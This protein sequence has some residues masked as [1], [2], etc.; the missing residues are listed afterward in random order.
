[1]DASPLLG[2]SQA[3][4]C[5]TVPRSPEMTIVPGTR[6]LRLTFQPPTSKAQAKNSEQY[7]AWHG[8][9]NNAEVHSNV[10]AEGPGVLPREESHDIANVNSDVIEIEAVGIRPAVGVTTANDPAGLDDVVDGELPVV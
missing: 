4:G 3:K 6:L 1:M 8:D 5:A 9:R 7:R 2:R 10:V